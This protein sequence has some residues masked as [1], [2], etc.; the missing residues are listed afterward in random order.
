[1][2]NSIDRKAKTPTQNMKNANLKEAVRFRMTVCWD[3][4]LYTWV[5]TR[6]FRRNLVFPSSEQD[7][8]SNEETGVI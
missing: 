6:T 2:A 3:K 1:M 5:E 8:F 7:V 4:T